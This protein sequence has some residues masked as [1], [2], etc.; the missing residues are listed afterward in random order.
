MTRAKRRE[1]TECKIKHREL[2][3]RDLG[4]QCGTVYARHR[5]KVALSSHYMHKGNV[6]HYVSCGFGRPSVRDKRNEVITKQ[7]LQEYSSLGQ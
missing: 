6:S 3:A 5:E 2:M 4:L 1:L 7:E